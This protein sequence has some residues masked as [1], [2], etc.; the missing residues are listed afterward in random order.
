MRSQ[1]AAAKTILGMAGRRPTLS[2]HEFSPAPSN[3][4]PKKK[5][6]S[7]ITEMINIGLFILNLISKTWR[8][9]VEGNVNLSKG[10]VGFWH[11]DMIP[12]WYLF[13]KQSPCALVSQSK[14]GELLTKIL[15]MWSF[16]VVRGSSSK[17]GSEALDEMVRLAKEN[18]LLIAP[19]GPRGPS[20]KMKPGIAVAA[21]R[22]QV[23]VYLIKTNMSFFKQFPKSWD[24]FKFPLPFC[25]ID[26]KINGPYIIESDASKEDINKLLVTFEEI[27]S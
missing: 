1:R 14:D 8:I 18:V 6:L 17:G 24:H 13:R 26:M 4:P 23:P 27:I 16:N 7:S 11:G 19:D 25:K 15:T 5:I 10:V 20:L 12:C 2:G 9:H 21:Q 3:S 22:A